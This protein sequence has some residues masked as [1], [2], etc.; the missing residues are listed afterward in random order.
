MITINKNTG[1]KDKITTFISYGK[2]AKLLL[3]KKKHKNRLQKI[4]R[5]MSYICRE[6]H[7]IEP[8]FKAMHPEFS[9]IFDHLLYL[10]SRNLQE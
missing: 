2:E 4:I 7:E 1:I 3:G 8:I 10:Y 6:L 9:D 5:E